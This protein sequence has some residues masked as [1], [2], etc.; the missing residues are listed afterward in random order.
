VTEKV[1][2]PKHSAAEELSEMIFSPEDRCFKRVV[3]EKRKVQYA[4]EF[5]DFENA[6]V[7]AVWKYDLRNREYEPEVMQGAIKFTKDTDE[8]RVKYDSMFDKSLADFG[9]GRV[10]D[11]ECEPR[12]LD[13]FQPKIQKAISRISD[14]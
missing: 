10:A 8:V 14:G 6:L 3:L 11:R 5:L 2:Q 4:V 1:I 13:L 12:D 9:E 7:A